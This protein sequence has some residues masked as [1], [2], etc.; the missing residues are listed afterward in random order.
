MNTA[1]FDSKAT[2]DFRR[3][4]LY[5]G[6]LYIYSPTASSIALCDFARQMCEEAFSP[7][8]PHEAQHHLPVEQFAWIL[9]DLKPKFIHHPTS[10]HLIQK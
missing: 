8:D 9:A 7:Y 5:R 6:Q 1:F 2:D 4:Q 10:K 3:K